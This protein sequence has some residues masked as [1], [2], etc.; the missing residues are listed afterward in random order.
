M[1]RCN[2]YWIRYPFLTQVLSLSSHCTGKLW[3]LL[4]LK[5]FSSLPSEGINFRAPL[6]PRGL[7]RSLCLKATKFAYKGWSLD[8]WKTNLQLLWNPVYTFQFNL[9]W[10]RLCGNWQSSVGWPKIFPV[11]RFY[12]S[13]SKKIFADFHALLAE[14][15]V[16][17]W[18]WMSVLGTSHQ[19]LK[20]DDGLA[21][22]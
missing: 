22:P 19:S 12:S 20:L 10:F 9:V 2:N 3:H 18:E 1:C 17:D 7:S 11:Q 14:M 4:S 16:C 21:P 6:F 5:V 8:H 15:N 13:F